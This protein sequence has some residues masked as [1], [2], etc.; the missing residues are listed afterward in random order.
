MKRHELEH[1]IRAAAAVANV[2]DIVVIGSQAILGEFP[3]APEEALRSMEADCYPLDEPS[4]A[5]LV[6]GAIGELSPFH[7]RFGYYAHG[8]SPETAILPDGWRERLVRVE[9]ENTG[10]AIGWCL[11]AVDLAASKLAAGREK[12]IEFVSTLLRHGCLSAE[13]LTKRVERLPDPHRVRAAQQLARL[14]R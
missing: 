14:Q 4:K 3:D 12:D 6:D 2:R 10:G 9:N 7:E 5:D 1:I 11:S 13:E 8:V